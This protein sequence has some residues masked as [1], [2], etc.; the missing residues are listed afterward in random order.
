M[1]KEIERIYALVLAGGYSSRMGQDK[2][3]LRWGEETLLER[4][5]RFWRKSGCVSQVLVSA[6]TET[7]FSA[8]QL[9]PDCRVVADLNPGQGPMAGIAAAFQRTDA[10]ALY[11]SAVDMPNL[12]MQALLPLPEGDAAV[13]CLHGR[14]EPLFGIYRRGVLPQAMRLLDNGQRKLR[15]LLEAVDTA[16]YHVPPIL[17]P[18]FQNL[19]T[20]EDVLLARAGTPPTIAVV[21]WHNAGKTTFLRGLIPA[22]QKYGLSVAALKHDVHGFSMDQEGTDTFY[23]RKAG[24][25]SAAILGPNG[26]A[27]LG[28]N[29]RSLEELRPMLSD[30]DVVLAE[31]FKRSWLPKLEVH[32]A[33]TGQRLITEDETLLAVVTDEPLETA[34]PQMGLTDFDRC[35][36]LLIEKL[37]LKTRRDR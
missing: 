9:P 19:N 17:E 11:V 34:A 27:A 26:W 6:G 31:G 16:Y 30:A 2:A 33:C 22:M 37:H 18:I 25:V 23:L 10:D 13:Y 8:S 7:H 3:L 35:A 32:R 36:E 29:Q 28:E 12:S 1:D 14:P 21:G 15:M 20:P 4:A 5:V 24:A